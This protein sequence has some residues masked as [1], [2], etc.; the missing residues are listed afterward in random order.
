VAAAALL[1]AA[2]QSAEPMHSRTS[3]DVLL[4]SDLRYSHIGVGTRAV[5][6]AEAFDELLAAGLVTG[7][8]DSWRAV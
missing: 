8:R 7:T 6:P 3:L 4:H 1:L 2:R 5:S